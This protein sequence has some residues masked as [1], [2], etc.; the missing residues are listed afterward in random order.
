MLVSKNHV[1]IVNLTIQQLQKQR[2]ASLPGIFFFLS[3]FP[4]IPTA[5]HLVFIRCS[6]ASVSGFVCMSFASRLMLHLK[7][8]LNTNA[9]RLPPA[10]AAT[11]DLNAVRVTGSLVGVVYRLL[12][13]ESTSF[14]FSQM[15]FLELST[16]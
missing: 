15:F 2:F 6:P 12:R 7:H 8:G 16:D 5:Y 14:Y 1:Y 4:P 13:F 3:F 10:R 9:S 11:I